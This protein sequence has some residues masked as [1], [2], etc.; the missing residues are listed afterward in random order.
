VEDHVAQAVVAEYQQA[1]VLSL[2]Q[3]QETQ[4]AQGI[5]G[6]VEAREFVREEQDLRVAHKSVRSL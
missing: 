5:A 1:R 3:A 2:G 4:V 6:A